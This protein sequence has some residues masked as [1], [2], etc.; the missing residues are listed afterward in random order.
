[1][2]VQ[3]VGNNPSLILEFDTADAETC[4]GPGEQLEDVNALLDRPDIIRQ[5]AGWPPGALRDELREYGAWD[6][7]ELVDYQAN[8][9]RLLWLAC[10]DVSENPD[11]YVIDDEPP[12]LERL[13]VLKEANR[14]N[15]LF[16]AVLADVIEREK[17]YE[18]GAASYITDVLRG[19][20]SS[21]VVPSLTSNND[22]KA[23]FIE[24]IDEIS[25]F[26]EDL[27]ENCVSQVKL[28]WPLYV[29]LPRLAYEEMI[30]EISN[31]LGI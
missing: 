15:A 18:G 24:F 13:A 29:G 25:Q 4:S 20:Y 11:A 2:R 10:R 23:W 27:L 16:S 3:W 21:G 30:V 28:E 26:Y 9:R 7:S 8:V 31:Q 14:S 6:G 1:M 17:E 12:I 22:C 5:A 19:D